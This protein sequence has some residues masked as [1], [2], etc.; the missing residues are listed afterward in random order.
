[1]NRP[2]HRDADTKDRREEPM[3]LEKVWGV[4]RRTDDVAVRVG[5]NA[6]SGQNMCLEAEASPHHQDGEVLVSQAGCRL[7][8]MVWYCGKDALLTTMAMLS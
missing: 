3:G 8:G 4:T 2:V 6:N 5:G 7:K 1:M